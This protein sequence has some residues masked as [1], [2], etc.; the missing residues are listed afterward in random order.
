MAVIISR[1]WSDKQ[2]KIYLTDVKFSKGFPVFEW[3]S[4]RNKAHKFT[5]RDEAD[6][7]VEKYYGN[8]GA[9][10]KDGYEFEFTEV[11]E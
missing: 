8:D 4:R 3:A 7:F 1:N 10:L 11:S 6:L 2:G 9:I 5:D